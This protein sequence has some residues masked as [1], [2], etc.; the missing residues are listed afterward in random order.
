MCTKLL[1][2]QK[3]EDK[4]MFFPKFE[5]HEEDK[6]IQTASLSTLKKMH[7]LENSLLLKYGYRLTMKSLS[8]SN[9]ENQ[10]VKLVSQI[11]N[12]NVAEALLELGEKYNI[13]H[14]RETSLYIQVFIKQWNIMNMKTPKKRQMHYRC[15]PRTINS[16]SYRYKI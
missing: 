11:F 9:L 14:Y 15:F 6:Y 8:P 1:A 3:N 5:N 12:R 13:P 4:C 16:F 10:N 7:N 2:K